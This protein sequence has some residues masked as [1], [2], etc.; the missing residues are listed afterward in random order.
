MR[1]ASL[2][3]VVLAAV[4]GVGLVAAFV[5]LG[6]TDRLRSS[7][8]V[9]TADPC[10]ATVVAT[11]GGSTEAEASTIL[12]SS[13]NAAA[14]ELHVS[15]EDLVLA[16]T[17]G[18]GIAGAAQML[19]VEPQALQDSVIGSI[20]KAV[21]EESAAG[22]LTPTTALAIKTLIDVV[23]PEQLLAAV[24]NEDGGCAPLEWKPVDDLKQIAAE[25][26]VLTG[27]RAACALGVSPIEA[28]SALADPAGLQGLAERSGK[29]QAEV[30]QAVRTAMIASVEQAQQ[31][32]AL[33]GTEGSVLG[34]AA[35]VAPVDRI[36]SIV[37]GDDDP[38]SEF[39]WSTT[40]STSQAL[41]EVALIGVVDAACQLGAPTFDVFAAL[42]NPGE[43]TTLEQTTGKSEEEINAAIKSGL[44][45]GL[46]EGQDAGDVSGLVAF[47]LNLALSQ[48]NVLDLL[49]NFVG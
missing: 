45:K 20:T 26:G 29:S 41:A 11:E 19:G 30:E 34:A 43:L 2:A 33:S 49:S 21:D 47:G 48:A 10:T 31:A 14:C 42:A 35:A 24:R 36:L 27:L 44:Q 28:V 4:V 17:D 15:R 8:A 6:G 23:P 40:S 37:R 12:L 32:G 39:P 9:A 1:R 25:V 7:Q 18:Q 16:L 5:A 22:R 13:L 3:L 38:C 46:T